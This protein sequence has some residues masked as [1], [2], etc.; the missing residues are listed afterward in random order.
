MKK[1]LVIEDDSQLR[2]MLRQ[3]LE[4]EGYTVVDI[5]NGREALDL[6]QQHEMDLVITDI[7]MP[8][9]DGV[10]T[11]MELKRVSPDLKI[12][13]VSGGSRYV[14]DENALKAAKEFGAEHVIFKPFEQK[15][16]LSA[17]EQLLKIKKL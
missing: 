12:I 2:E 4:R 5:P 16:I 7:F 3:T 17:V 10:E 1:I 6:H 13:A 8:E 15:E 11:I 9:K 14:R